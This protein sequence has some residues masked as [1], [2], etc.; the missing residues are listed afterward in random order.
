MWNNRALNI[1]SARR[2]DNLAVGVF[3]KRL[4]AFFEH[5]ARPA[6]LDKDNLRTRHSTSNERFT[7]MVP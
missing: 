3:F 4:V 1:K 2:I 7:L 5:I 6:S